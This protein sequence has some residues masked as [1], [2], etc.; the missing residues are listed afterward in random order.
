MLT[1]KINKAGQ[2]GF[3]SFNLTVPFK[4]FNNTL[5]LALL[6]FLTLLLLSQITF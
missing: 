1:Y 4:T 6:T 5:I 3:Y 2:R